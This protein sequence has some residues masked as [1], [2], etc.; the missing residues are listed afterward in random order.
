VTNEQKV[1]RFEKALAQGGGT[2]TISD[3]LD[4]IGEGKAVCWTNGDSVVVTEVLV[5]PRLR[6]CNYWIGVGNLRE[7]SELQP[8][9]DAWARTEGCTVATATG[10]MGWMR[11]I[12]TPL[13]EGWRPA[14]IK[15]VRDLRHE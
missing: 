3:V 13:G 4:R 8:A 10:R 1:R 11:V 2:H 6:V 5:F 15:Y 12:K 9:I 14:G 7:C